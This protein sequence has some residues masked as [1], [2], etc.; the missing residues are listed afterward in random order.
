LPK[1]ER[2]FL[3]FKQISFEKHVLAGLKR[4]KKLRTCSGSSVHLGFAVTRSGP[5]P[6][7]GVSWHRHARRDFCIHSPDSRNARC[8]F[9]DS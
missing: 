6:D 1:Y 5:P 4:P 8:R 2:L 3:L 7:P 9:L